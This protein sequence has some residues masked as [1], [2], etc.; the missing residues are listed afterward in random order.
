MP[1]AEYI[2]ATRTTTALLSAL[3]DTSN[4]PAWVAIDRRFRP[5]LAGLGRKLG[6]TESEAEEVAQQSLA[7][8]VRAYQQGRYDR[9]K[10]R[11]SSWIISI[12][13]HQTLALIRA[14]KHAGVAGLT[15]ISD[16]P[17]EHSLRQIWN[18]ERDRAILAQALSILRERAELDDRTLLAFELVGLRGVPV[19]EA[20]SQCEMEV[21]QVYVAK[22]RVVKKLRSVVEEL[23]AA[24]EDDL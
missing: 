19:T 15:A 20:A 22:S 14:R 4:Q 12:A 1:A 9:E 2:N 13:H 24:F 5:I 6:L 16:T 21:D 3:R 18:D 8:L 10:G 11:L 17:D 7:E 23:T